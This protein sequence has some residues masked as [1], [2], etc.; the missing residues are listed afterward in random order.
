MNQ[1]KKI[2]FVSII[3]TIF[4]LLSGCTNTVVETHYPED[5]P[6]S[7]ILETGDD[8]ITAY[9]AQD[10]CY[11]YDAVQELPS[12]VSNYDPIEVV[13]LSLGDTFVY[14]TMTITLG[15]ELV[16]ASYTRS[17]DFSEERADFIPWWRVPG[18]K[19]I[20]IPVSVFC[21]EDDPRMVGSFPWMLIDSNYDTPIGTAPERTVWHNPG[22]EPSMHYFPW[23]T[24]LM[25]C[26]CCGNYTFY[27][28]V[29]EPYF[30]SHIRLEYVGDGEYV[31]PFILREGG[32]NTDIV[33]IFEL[34][35]D[36]TWPQIPTEITITN[37]E[38]QPD[39]A[40]QIG[41]FMVSVGADVL[42]CGD[43]YI[44]VGITLFPVSLTNISDE[45]EYLTSLNPYRLNS[46]ACY[47]PPITIIRQNGQDI[48]LSDMPPVAPGVSMEFY[49][50]VHAFVC[51]NSAFFRPFRLTEISAA[52][53]RRIKITHNH[54]YFCL[55][56]CSWCE[57]CNHYG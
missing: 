56:W 5:E 28:S 9:R 53:S 12:D 7:F 4:C 34:S 22:G 11:T 18:D 42:L 48:P 31:L 44:A 10:Y 20:Y 47:P 21:A 41:N 8:D 50:P 39:E 25:D 16:F 38:R 33:R 43:P 27:Q 13:R 55:P 46:N 32:W 36:I 52:D 23:S 2:L 29:F 40:V 19:A 54:Y 17:F 6:A 37:I 15:T 57:G 30:E 1:L 45:Y 26:D 49:L 14:Q 24:Q 35:L 51:E 3:V